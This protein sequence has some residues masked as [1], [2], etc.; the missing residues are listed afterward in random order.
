M[1]ASQRSVVQA[2]VDELMK[3]IHAIELKFRDTLAGAQLE[4]MLEQ[5]QA[6]R[7]LIGLAIQGNTDGSDML[8]CAN[9]VML[10]LRSR[11]EALRCSATD[12]EAA[13]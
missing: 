11:V 5:L 8:V 13:S 12:R 10:H 9:A 1:G 3:T 7:C 2:Q 4:D 6:A